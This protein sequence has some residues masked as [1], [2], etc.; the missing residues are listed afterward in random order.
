MY[1]RLLRTSPR[2]RR[3]ANVL[4]TADSRMDHPASTAWPL[5]E[6]EHN[7][8]HWLNAQT[9]SA[10]LSMGPW[11]RV[12]TDRRRHH[13]C[14][15]GAC[16]ARQRNTIRRGERGEGRLHLARPPRSFTEY[17]GLGHFTALPAGRQQQREC[18][19]EPAVSLHHPNDLGQFLKK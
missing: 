16:W 10:S 8:R 5:G 1:P 7:H 4:H 19:D 11:R 3:P 15:D 18:Q 13:R 9:M 12:A 17:G 2:V 6:H 14:S